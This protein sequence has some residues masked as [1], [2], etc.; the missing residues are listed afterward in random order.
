MKKLQLNE[1]HV[2]YLIKLPES[3]MGYQVVDIALKNGQLFKKRVV[4]NSSLLLLEN[5]EDIDP[6][7]IE[8]IE[9]VN[10]K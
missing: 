9:L 6:D 5:N 8:K 3:G 7:Y 10:K 4:L 2:Q 1:D